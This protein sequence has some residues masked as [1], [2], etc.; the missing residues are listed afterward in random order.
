LLSSAHAVA[1][2]VSLYWFGHFRSLREKATNSRR[3]GDKPNRRAINFMSCFSDRDSGLT[4]STHADQQ[5][6]MHDVRERVRTI[7]RISLIRIATKA[8]TVALGFAVSTRPRMI[9]TQ[10]N[11]WL[12]ASTVCFT[13]AISHVASAAHPAK[14]ALPLPTSPKAEASSVKSPSGEKSLAPLRRT[15]ALPDAPT[16]LH[17]TAP[18]LVPLSQPREKRILGM[19]I[20]TFIAFGLSG[21]SVGGAVAT[22]FAAARGNDPSTCDSRCTE[23]GVRERALLLTTGVLTG[24]AAAGV[25]IGIT[26]MFKAPKQPSR[27]AIYP[28]FDLGLSG[29]KAV[30]KVGWV[31]S[32]F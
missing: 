8:V 23:H 17:L 29:Q 2:D 25:T 18:R 14:A 19:R 28:R 12:F 1:D 4:T 10:L 30:A 16:P 32:S 26:L 9:R 31:F 24:L 22:G 15:S 11:G 3:K 20:P 5:T 13:L 21:L 7:V 6:G 27:D